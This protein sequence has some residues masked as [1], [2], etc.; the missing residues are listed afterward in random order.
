MLSRLLACYEVT[1][2]LESS[3]SAH[4][5]TILWGGD[6]SVSSQLFRVGAFFFW[7][8]GCVRLD[9]GVN[10]EHGTSFTLVISHFSNVNRPT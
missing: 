8:I 6:Y 1:V 4:L 3:Q 9:Q 5:C 2:T 7:F 10:L